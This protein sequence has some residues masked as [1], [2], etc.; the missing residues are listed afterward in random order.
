MHRCMSLCSESVPPKETERTADGAQTVRQ[1]AQPSGCSKAKIL[2]KAGLVWQH[3]QYIFGDAFT[4]SEQ[5]TENVES[6][7]IEI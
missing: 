2:R 4:F 6:A 1:G 7:G 3:V 5:K